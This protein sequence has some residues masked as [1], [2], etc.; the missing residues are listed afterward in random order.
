[1]ATSGAWLRNTAL[2]YWITS[3]FLKN[4]KWI[5]IVISLV[6]VL[7]EAGMDYLHDEMDSC[8]EEKIISTILQFQGGVKGER[9]QSQAE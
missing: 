8:V 1:M 4:I 5:W 7:K 2:V 3:M 6:Q 9:E